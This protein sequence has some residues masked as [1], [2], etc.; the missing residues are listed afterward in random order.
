MPHA[1]LRPFFFL[2]TSFASLFLRCQSL[3]LGCV[4][5]ASDFR[6]RLLA[7]VKDGFLQTTGA[8]A[9]VLLIPARRP[10]QDLIG[11]SALMHRMA[12]CSRVRRPHQSFQR[13]QLLKRD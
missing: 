2:F 5:G 11:Q 8:R 9:Q 4:L 3:Q 1:V 7:S 12:F 10:H 6:D 13:L